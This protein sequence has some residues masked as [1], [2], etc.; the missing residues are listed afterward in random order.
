MS[1]VETKIPKTDYFL[2]RELENPVVLKLKKNGFLRRKLDKEVEVTCPKCEGTGTYI[3]PSKDTPTCGNYICSCGMSTATFLSEL[4]I[5]E[6]EAD[7]RDKLILR[8]GEFRYVV[9]TIQRR[10]TESGQ[11]FRSSGQLLEI[12]DRGTDVEIHTFTKETLPL[13]LSRFL[14]FYKKDFR[15][16]GENKLRP[17]DLPERIAKALLCDGGESGAMNDLRG[18]V[19]CPIVKLN[20]QL[21]ISRGYDK[22]SRFWLNIPTNAFEDMAEKVS[23]DEA[24]RAYVRLQKVFAGVNFAQESDEVAAI[25]SILCAVLRPMISACP[26]IHINAPSPGMGKSSLT[27]AIAMIPTKAGSAT[28][29]SFPSSEEEMQRLLASTLR[30]SPKIVVFDNVTTDL[31]PYSA[32]CTC[33]TEGRFSARML[34]SST[35]I[36]VKNESIFIS[37]GNQTL[38]RHDLVRR[39]LVIELASHPFRPVERTQ[40]LEEIVT[41]QRISIIQ[42]AI[43]IFR[44][45]LLAGAV[46]FDGFASF[47]EWDRKC[48]FPL[49]WLEKADPLQRTFSLLKKDDGTTEVSELLTLLQGRFKRGEFKVSDIRGWLEEVPQNEDDDFRQRVKIILDRWGLFDEASLNTR[50][51]GRRLLQIA[52]MSQT[53]N[54]LAIVKRS[55]PLVF[56]VTQ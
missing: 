48:R 43:L 56:K 41:Q 12:V 8:E 23:R 34:G 49:L 53:E 44:A 15:M 38:P 54:K 25:S 11:I 5:S 29:L 40:S 32:L 17:I 36:D 13:L 52:E 4:K 51:L 21:E 1:E 10:L 55:S 30:N 18:V 19:E 50:K 47:S 39:T 24:Q 14:S 42:D 9:L 35:L 7:W 6:F 46:E 33:L 27:R 31:V 37:N 45:W 2:V 20:G 3:L 22:D 28:Y 26:M 16:A